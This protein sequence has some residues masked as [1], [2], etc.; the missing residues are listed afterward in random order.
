MKFSSAIS[1]TGKIP[2][3]YWCGEHS[4]NSVVLCH[5]GRSSSIQCSKYTIGAA[6]SMQHFACLLGHRLLINAVTRNGNMG[7]QDSNQ[8]KKEK[9]IHH[10]AF[11][12]YTFPIPLLCSHYSPPLKGLSHEMDLAFDDMHGQFC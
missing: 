10:H 2:P 4:G 12:C 11:I 3:I 1:A 7:L 8:I 6:N 9:E 5:S